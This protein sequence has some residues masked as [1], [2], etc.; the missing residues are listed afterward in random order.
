MSTPTTPDTEGTMNPNPSPSSRALQLAELMAQI[1]AENPLISGA[2]AVIKAV[3]MLPSPLPTETQVMD[4]AVLSDSEDDSD[5]D[6]TTDDSEDDSEDDDETDMESSEDE[7]SD[8]L[9]KVLPGTR[10]VIAS[11]STSNPSTA[12]MAQSTSS[13]SSPPSPPSTPIAPPMSGPPAPTEEELRQYFELNKL[14]C[15][16]FAVMCIIMESY[17]FAH[18][19]VH[20]PAFQNHL[21]PYGEPDPPPPAPTPLEFLLC[22]VGLPVP[23]LTQADLENCYG[24]SF[25]KL[26]NPPPPMPQSFA[27]TPLVVEGEREPIPPYI[28]PTWGGA[29]PE[30]ANKKT[31]RARLQEI[32]ELLERAIASQ[33]NASRTPNIP[34]PS[35]QQPANPPP[36]PANPPPVPPNQNDVPMEDGP[37]LCRRDIKPLPR[38]AQP[39]NSVVGVVKQIPYALEVATDAGCAFVS[40]M[41][42]LLDIEGAGFVGRRKK[43]RMSWE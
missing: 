26:T 8:Q 1:Q 7:S 14:P 34:G 24:L 42:R 25:P 20:S 35:Q 23:L 22:S 32:K 5:G 27:L 19:H 39:L 13:F 3:S 37:Q 6:I 33:S 2:D 28:E 12:W 41:K 15:Q 31:D 43:I 18:R 38:R 4:R 30:I 21:L 17:F 11:T 10:A 16:I 29:P 40:G 36:M 9:E